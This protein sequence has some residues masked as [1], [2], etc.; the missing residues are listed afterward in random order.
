MN[1]VNNL[2]G[3]VPFYFSFKMMRNRNITKKICKKHDIFTNNGLWLFSDKKR[4]SIIRHAD[5]H[6]I[7]RMA[8]KVV[9]NIY[10]IYGSGFQYIDNIEYNVDYISGYKWEK[11]KYFKHYRIINKDDSDIKVVWEL[12]RGHYLLWLGEAYL[13]T[14][15]EKYADKVI[16]L[17]EHWIKNNRYL[18]S[19]N[20]TSA[21]EVSIRALNWIYAINMI[22]ESRAYKNTEIGDII[23]YLYCHYDFIYNNLEKRFLYSANHYSANIMGLIYLAILFKSDVRSSKYINDIKFSLEEFYFEVRTQLLPS[24]VHYERSIGYHKLTAEIY[25]LTYIRLIAAGI[26]IPADITARLIKMVKYIDQYIKPN[27]SVPNIGDNDDGRILPFVSYGFDNHLYLLD[28]A[29]NIFPD[30]ET[31]KA[32]RPTID[33]LIM[34]NYQYTNR[35]IKSESREGKKPI[36]HDDAGIYIIENDNIYLI[37]LNTLPSGYPSE[38]KSR[39][40][41]HTHCDLLSFELTNNEEDIFVDPGTFTYT[42]DVNVRNIFRSTNYHNTVSIDSKD[43]HKIN[44]N[45]VFGYDDY[46]Y[47]DDVTLRRTSKCSLFRGSYK[48]YLYN[49][50]K[51]KHYRTFMLPV[52]ENNLVITDEFTF[53]D[54]HHFA[55]NFHFHPGISAEIISKSKVKCTTR[56]NNNIEIMFKSKV[57]YSANII[58][59]DYSPSYGVILSAKKIQIILSSKNSFTFN[60]EIV[61]K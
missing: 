31:I 20:W 45:N 13:I 53:L 52:H 39:I 30:F 35:S 44:L 56:N 16:D 18:F 38:F 12:S 43:H 50:T 4:K 55:I 19:V 29:Q 25:L 41:S 40:T 21:M 15:D 36:I 37:I 47:P 48:G 59:Y 58:D 22:K 9:N 3:L 7:M 2:F 61:F 42:R 27:G 17:L 34:F 46:S 51:V 28:I 24:G 54:K 26:N 33:S 32:P 57:P 6:N 10:P 49:E 60:T 11:S 1:K 5:S 23:L 14:Q 8:N